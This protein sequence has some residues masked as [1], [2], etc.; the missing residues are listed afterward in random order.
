MNAVL[1]SLAAPLLQ[2][3]DAV[4]YLSCAY[5]MVKNVLAYLVAVFG[6]T[7]VEVDV[8]FPVTS[9]Q[10]IIGPVA[11]ALDANPG[12]RLATFSHIVSTPAVVL[13]VEVDALAR[14]RLGVED[15]HAAGP[16]ACRRILQQAGPTRAAAQ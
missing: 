10:D 4:M 5:G 12:L 7:L 16:R 9:P 13:P 1:R 3:G 14:Q 2:K 11:A 8:E 15:V 6:A